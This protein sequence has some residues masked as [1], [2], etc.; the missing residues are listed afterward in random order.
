[1]AYIELPLTRG[2]PRATK[3]LLGGNVAKEVTG[4]S[5]HMGVVDSLGQYIKLNV[6]A[7]IWHGPQQVADS[8]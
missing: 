3:R 4:P 2:L 5:E 7:I 8:V 1:M 6:W